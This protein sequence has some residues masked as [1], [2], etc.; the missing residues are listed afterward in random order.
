MVN[1]DNFRFIVRDY[2][3][4]EIYVDGFYMDE[5]KLPGTPIWDILQNVQSWMHAN[6][7]YYNPK[8]ET[9]VI[10]HPYRFLPKDIELNKDLYE[11]YKN[12][13]KQKMD[14]RRK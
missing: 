11:E 4:V 1:W 13:V 6:Y 10:S 12:L 9:H 14:E 7:T 3:V 5:E 8:L 2:K